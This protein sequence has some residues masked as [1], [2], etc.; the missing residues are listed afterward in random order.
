MESKDTFL[1]LLLSIIWSSSYIFMKNIAPSIGALWTADLR[2]FIGGLTLFIY[3]KLKGKDLKLK[4]YW[5]HY[6][7]IGVINS[8]IPFSV[9]SYAAIFIPT[10]YSVII[11]STTPLFGVI[12]SYL[13]LKEKINL[14]KILGLIFG[15]AGVFLISQKGMSHTDNNMFLI[16]ILSCLSGSL[17]YGLGSVFT[18]KY[19]SHLDPM[20][21]SSA[22]QIMASIALLPLC[23]TY[24]PSNP[25][26]MKLV[27]SL[28]ALA[29]I[30]S[31]IAYLIYYYLIIK[32]GPTKALTVTFLMPMFGFV[33][34]KIFLNEEI[35]LSII[36]GSILILTGT[37]FVLK[38]PK[39]LEKIKLIK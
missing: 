38:Q 2:L 13:I 16:G 29:I 1:L 12:F 4:E 5:K 23:L 3:F 39:F 32:I 22:S 30:C 14:S 18:R 6:L 26:T 24:I 33:W 35:N 10:S 34:G 21:V 37:Y 15:F 9:Y 7:A 8:A 17:C 25:I 31:S 28:L 36:L 11:N 20:S 19:A 27:L